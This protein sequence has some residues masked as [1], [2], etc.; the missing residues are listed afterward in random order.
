[1]FTTR[2]LFSDFIFVLGDGIGLCLDGN[3]GVV[4]MMIMMTALSHT[5]YKPSEV[6]HAKVTFGQ[7]TDLRH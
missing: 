3:Y 7:S 6:R 2:Q 4:A 1:M 5:L